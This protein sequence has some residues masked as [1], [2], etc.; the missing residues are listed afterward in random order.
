MQRGINP[1]AD[2]TCH[3]Y[4][5]GSAADKGKTQLGRRDTENKPNIAII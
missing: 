4:R 5:T 2:G 3:H 1:L